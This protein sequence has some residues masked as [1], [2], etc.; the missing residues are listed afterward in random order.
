MFDIVFAQLGVIP[1][2][3]NK[4]AKIVAAA[5]RYFITDQFK[6]K[7]SRRRSSCKIS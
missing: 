6:N 7:D 5:E 1:R 2:I 4:F 3:K